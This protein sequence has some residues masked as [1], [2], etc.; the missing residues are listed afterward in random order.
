M[1]W[2][3]TASPR[4]DSVKLSEYQPERRGDSQ[5]AGSPPQASRVLWVAAARVP[6]PGGV[7]EGKGSSCGRAVPYVY[8]GAGSGSEA[9][10]LL[11]GKILYL[12][13]ILSSISGN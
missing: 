13:W 5:W 10:F 8:K 6:T 11:L 7:L 9:N 12:L 3:P 2:Q 4:S 1:G